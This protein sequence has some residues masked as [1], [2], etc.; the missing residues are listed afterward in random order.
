MFF[1]S[2]LVLLFSLKARFPSNRAISE[3]HI[4]IGVYTYFFTFQTY[5]KY[6]INTIEF[7]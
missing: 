4:S 7:S 2:M 6:N 1:I 3:D 5:S